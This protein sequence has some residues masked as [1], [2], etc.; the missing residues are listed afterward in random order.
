MDCPHLF[1]ANSTP[2]TFIQYCVSDRGN[3]SQLQTPFGHFQLGAQGEGYGFC[4]QDPAPGTVYFDYPS[5]DS[6]NWKLPQV[7]SVNGS[8]IKIPRTT[9]DGTWTLVQTLSKVAA[10]GSINVVMALT[11]NQAADKVAYLVRF[12]DVDPD[13]QQF[14]PF[15]GSSFQS[16]FAWDVR[17]NSF[18]LGL[19][20]ENV[21][22]W[23]GFQQGYIQRIPNPPNPCAFAFN[24]DTGGY[25]NGFI[26][27]KDVSLVYA[28]VGN[29]PAHKTVTV[30][31][32]YSGT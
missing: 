32:S 2:N 9:T 13:G 25:L 21:G 23:N 17:N 1:H 8:A 28:Y 31:L 27:S 19:Q 4:Q 6:G 22:H 15:A 7:L 3:I 16:A 30:T 18:R 29:V 10:T 20:V 26:E 12:A 5:G 14:S 11:N 24:S